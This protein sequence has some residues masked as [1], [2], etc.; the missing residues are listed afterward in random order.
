MSASLEFSF[1]HHPS[2]ASQYGDT[3]FVV[4]ILD[5]LD[6]E[7]HALNRLASVARGAFL[8]ALR[9]DRPLVDDL[10][11]HMADCSWLQRLLTLYHRIPAVSV[12][13]GIGTLG[14]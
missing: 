1:L 4:P 12:A 8:V 2:V 3:G 5:T 11:T 7:A 14:G 13:T 9:S 10:F 6:R